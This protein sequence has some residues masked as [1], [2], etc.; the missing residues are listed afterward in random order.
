MEDEG[1]IARNVRLRM[2]AKGFTP[3]GLS[4]A[5]TLN[6]T[7]VRDILKGKSRNPTNARL[8]KLAAALDCRVA[9]L[10]GEL[11]PTDGGS[12]ADLRR[13]LLDEFDAMDARER[14]MLV[15]IAKS[16]RRDPPAAPITPDQRNRPPPFRLVG[17]LKENPDRVS[18]GCPTK[19][20]AAQR[21]RAE[22]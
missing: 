6:E 13:D 9:D 4:L 15:R 8:Q 3:K 16:M 14:E 19:V 1:L 17:G 18:D 5:A 2:E 22:R 20:G 11:D 10:T 7:Y 12:P 21:T